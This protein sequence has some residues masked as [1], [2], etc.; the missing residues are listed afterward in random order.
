MVGAKQPETR[1]FILVPAGAV[2]PAVVCLRHYIALHRG[3]CSGAA[4]SEAGEEAWPPSLKRS[5][6]GDCQY[7][8]RR[9]VRA[10]CVV[11]SVV[12]L[13]PL[14]R[15]GSPSF[16][17]PRR[18]RFTGML[19]CLATSGGMA[20]SAG[21]LAAV[22]AALAPVLSSWRIPYLNRGGF[23]GEGIVVR[24]GVLRRARGSC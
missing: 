17:R 9:S 12:R 6:W 16:Y 23:E 19:H 22:L 14:R 3:A 24:C 8:G 1:D 2:R 18:G 21:E 4:T 7:R 15:G 13:M 5:D 11:M 20:C 10:K